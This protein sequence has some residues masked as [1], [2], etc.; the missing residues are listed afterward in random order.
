MSIFNFKSSLIQGQAGEAK[1]HALYPN[2]IRTDGRK[3][4]F[5]LP[6]GRTAELKTESRTTAQTPNLAI[7]LNSSAGRIGALERAVFDK[8]TYIIYMFADGKYYVYDPVALMAYVNTAKHRICNIPN[9]GY[10]SIVMLVPRS[11]VKHLEASHE[12]L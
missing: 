10:T 3:E 4:D 12:H 8:V 5:I 2:W 6:D 1:F 7:E 11:A 9:Q